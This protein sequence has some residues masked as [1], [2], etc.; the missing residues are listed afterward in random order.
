[1]DQATA[2]AGAAHLGNGRRGGSVAK[3]RPWARTPA[4]AQRRCVPLSPTATC[5]L[6]IALMRRGQSAES[7]RGC[8]VPPQG[9]LGCLFSS[10]LRAL[11][12]FMASAIE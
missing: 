3:R 10:S 8:V 4:Q 5:A 11:K 6:E 9:P 7:S 12:R 2:A 1:M